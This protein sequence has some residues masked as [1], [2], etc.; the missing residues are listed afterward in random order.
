M[1][2]ETRRDGPGGGLGRLTPREHEILREVSKGH[3]N[4][5]IAQS[6]G[7]SVTTVRTHIQSILEK[8]EVHS[9]LE[10]MAKAIELGLE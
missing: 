6:L 2:T 9:K 1:R 4:R 7:V 3:D 10:A 8:L 5:A